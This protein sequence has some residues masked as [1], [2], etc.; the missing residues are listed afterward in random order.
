MKNPEETETLL[1]DL[2]DLR[3]RFEGGPGEWWWW[4]GGDNLGCSG[5]SASRDTE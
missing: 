1:G 2:E 5:Q 4:P 3:G